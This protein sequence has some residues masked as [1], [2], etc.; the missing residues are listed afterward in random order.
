MVGLAGQQPQSEDGKTMRP[1]EA[2]GIQVM[3]IGFLVDAD[4][5]MI[6]RGPMVTSALQQLLNQTTWQDLDY[7]VVDMPPG[8]GDIQLT[9]SQQ[10]PG[11]RRGHRHD[12]AEYRDARCAQ[13][14]CHV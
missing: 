9:L 6:W 13:R 1:M 2:H 4:Q 14:P 8:T 11:Q 10:V 3:S 7:L 5:P 12:A